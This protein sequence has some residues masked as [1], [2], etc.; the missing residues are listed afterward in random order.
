MP[1]ASHLTT[2][3]RH[4]TE[5]AADEF[6]RWEFAAVPNSNNPMKTTLIRGISSLAVVM[7]GLSGAAHAQTNFGV[8]TPSS[9]FQFFI[10]GANNTGQP[11]GGGL[12]NSPPLTLTAGQTY[13]FTISDASIHPMEIVTSTPSSGSAPH[14]TNATPVSTTSGTMTLVIPATGFPTTLYYECAIHF[15]YG[16]ITVVPPVVNAPPANH[17]ISIVLTPDTITLTSDG[18]NTTYN[19]VPQFNSNVFDGNWQDVPS[20]T[21]VFASGTNTTRFNRLDAVC[22]PNVF[23]RISQRPP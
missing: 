10:D 2:E 4:T 13:T 5:R 9:T 16:V 12:N 20:F 17:I 18:T 1:C 8:T 7:L 3:T 11:A 22:G 19:L 21:N 15:F 6:R 23:L 14:Y